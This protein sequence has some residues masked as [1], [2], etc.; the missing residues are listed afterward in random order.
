MADAA[1]GEAR[2]LQYT[3]WHRA[4]AFALKPV[5]IADTIL[6]GSWSRNNQSKY[7]FD[8]NVGWVEHSAGL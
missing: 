2:P 3:G 4:A 5:A 1:V 8:Q 6:I 7:Y